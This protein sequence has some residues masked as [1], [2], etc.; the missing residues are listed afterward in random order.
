V[1]TP[2]PELA[3]GPMRYGAILP[4]TEIGPD[5][6][7]VVS[8]AQAAEQSGFDHL[9]VYDHVLG[10][11]TSSRPHWR[12]AYTA[13]D[14]FH[15]PFVL[16]GFLAAHTAMEL[17]AGVLVLPQRQTALVAKQAAEV[18]LLTGGR[19]RLGVGVGWND[20]EYEALGMDFA[21]RGAR[22]E[23]QIALL[24]L[25]WTRDVVTFDGRF[26]QVNEAG[27]LPRPVQRP[28][29]VWMGGGAGRRVLERIGRLADGWIS[30][31]APGRGLEEAWQHVIAAATSAGRAPEAIGLEGRVEP[32]A[33]ASLERLARQLERWRNFGP[34]THVSVSGLHAGLTPSGHAEFVRRAGEAIFG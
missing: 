5:P 10:A 9:L 17:V 24:R 18:D 15:E 21:N 19:F 29:P 27:I 34:T 13:S 2:W 23:E 16:Y 26:H 1:I 31:A 3:S 6:R 4:Q 25:L 32:G 7:N 11:D 14:Q 20:V 30:L 12:G 8:F 22:Y 33:G 28:I